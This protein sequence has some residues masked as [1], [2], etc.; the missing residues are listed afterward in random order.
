MKTVKFRDT[1][2]EAVEMTAKEFQAQWRYRDLT[3]FVLL[4]N[5][6]AW[7]NQQTCKNGYKGRCNCISHPTKEWVQFDPK[8]GD[9]WTNPHHKRWWR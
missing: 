1:R 5:G 4:D 6:T 9:Y 8:T 2:V 3:G 7:Y